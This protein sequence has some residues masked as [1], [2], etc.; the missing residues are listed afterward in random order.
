MSASI[1]IGQSDFTTANSGTPTKNS[2]APVGLAFDSSGNLWVVDFFANRVLEFNPPFTNGMNANL[3]LGH[4]DFTSQSPPF[5]PTNSGF[6]GPQSIAF[7]A[8]GN[9]WVADTA[10][11]RVLEFKP[12]FASGMGASL[13]IGQ[14][15]FVSRVRATTVSGFDG[16]RGIALDGTGN[17]WVADSFNN[18]V[19]QFQPPFAS[20]MNA[21]LVLGQSNFTSNAA[22]AT[23]SGFS[24]PSGIAFDSSRNLIVDDS[25]NNRTLGFQAPFSNNQNAT[26]VLGQTDF[27]SSA[28]ATTATGQNTPFSVSTTAFFF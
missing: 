28:A 1:V 2:V 16:P 11:S 10:N 24:H 27:T 4:A 20:G 9:L 14:S 17:L 23:Q 6:A 13:V 7:D 18:R 8:N 15:D 3:V 5:P 21:S 26:L 19:L 22:A 25:R 12:P